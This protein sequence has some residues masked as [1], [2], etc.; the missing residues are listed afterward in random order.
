M[1]F[2]SLQHTQARRSTFLR[3]VPPPAVFR[4]QG[5]VTLW[6]AYALRA[7][8][9]SVSHRR[10]SWD[11][12]FGAFSFR[13]VSTA[14]PRG[15]THIPFRP[16]VFPPPKRW[17]G[18]TGR[19]FWAL[20]LPGVPGDRNMISVPT[21]GCSLGLRPSRVCRREPGP[22]FRPNSSHALRRS[23]L[24]ADPAGASESRSTPAW[25]RPTLPAS[26]GPDRTTLLGFSHQHDP[27]RSS[28]RP[29]GLL[30]SPCAAPYI[31]AGRRRALNG[32]TSLYRSR[33]G[34]A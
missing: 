10:R 13:K 28:E 4:L 2:C 6:A 16:P 20:T 34:Y 23:S 12:P 29:P 5:L 26:R 17:A 31:A 11:S 25:P 27:E 3:A 22:G 24:A 32:P 18:P 7:P 15:R 8:A 14:F 30:V 21:A 33:S 9:G 1:G 19:G